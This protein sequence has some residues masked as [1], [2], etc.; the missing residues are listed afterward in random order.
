[1]GCFMI[2]TNYITRGVCELLADKIPG[3]YA[4]KVQDKE[5]PLFL[6]KDKT[7]SYPQIRVSPFI[8]KSDTRYQKYIEHKYRAYRHWEYGVF[9]VDIYTTQLQQCQ[10]IYDVLTQRL[11]DFFNL[12]TVIFNWNPDFEQIDDN[13]YRNKSFALMDDDLFKDIY[14]IEI[15]GV[16]IKRVNSKENLKKNSYYPNNEFLYLKTDLDL[17][18]IEIKVL[19][20]GRLFSN[21]LSH[22]DMGIHAYSLSKQRNLSALENN[23]VERISFDLEILFS[24]KLNREELPT[25]KRIA[26]NKANVR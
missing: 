8:E 24:K 26:F 7:T 1:M 23:E 6:N 10:D 2:S 20:Q 11:F 5:I 21:G 14:G 17:K 3:G 22:S 18:K 19:M 15:D 12:E 16:K 25:L 9:Q 4:L 13:T